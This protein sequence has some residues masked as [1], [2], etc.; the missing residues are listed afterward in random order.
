MSKPKLKWQSPYEWLDWKLGQETDLVHLRNIIHI[1]AGRLG[2]DDIQDIFQGEMDEDGYFAPQV[3]CPAAAAGECTTASI[4]EHAALHTW[5]EGCL[6]SPTDC[7]SCVVVGGED[8]WII[9]RHVA[10]IR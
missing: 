6:D 4:C 5:T 2:A 9:T 1:L 8:D 7:P 10:P 3:Q